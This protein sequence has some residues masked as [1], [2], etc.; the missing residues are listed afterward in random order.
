MLL[1]LGDL[2]L[3]LSGH[4]AS[5]TAGI[6]VYHYALFVRSVYDYYVPLLIGVGLVCN[7]VSVIVFA[8]YNEHGVDAT[9]SA[10]DRVTS[11]SS[12]CAANVAQIIKE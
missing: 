3:N 4:T 10:E 7:V 2:P 9:G 8:N 1:F 6:T 5:A 12:L 11:S